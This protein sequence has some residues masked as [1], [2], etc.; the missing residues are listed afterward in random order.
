MSPILPVDCRLSTVDSRYEAG[1]A[2]S[3]AV[4][5]EGTGVTADGASAGFK[6]RPAGVRSASIGVVSGVGRAAS[7]ACAACACRLS[8]AALEPQPAAA[9]PVAASNNAAA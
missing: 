7:G 5:G 8:P 9:K 1:F 2:G 6:I 4:G 3:P